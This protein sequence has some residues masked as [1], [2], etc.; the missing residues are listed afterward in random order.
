MTTTSDEQAAL[1]MLFETTHGEEDTDLLMVAKRK[2]LAAMLAL[3]INAVRA[4]EEE[5]CM[6][7]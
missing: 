3:R 7:Q 2:A 1:I 6:A 4:A 5:T